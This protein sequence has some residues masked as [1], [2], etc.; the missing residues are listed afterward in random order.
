[1]EHKISGA[2]HPGRQHLAE[3]RPCQDRIRMARGRNVVCCALADGAGSRP[4]SQ[5]G[6]ECVTRTVTELL[7]QDFERLWAL[8]E[9]LVIERILACCT[10]ALRELEHPIYDLACTLEFCGAHMDGRYLAGHL[11]DGVMILEQCGETSVFSY[12]ENGE[13]QN[14]TCFITE[15]DAKEYLRIKR[16]R[17]NEGGVLLLMSD[18]MADS[19]FQY[20]TQTPAKVCGTLAEWIRDGDEEQVSQALAENMQTVFSK[21]TA[22][23]MSLILLCWQ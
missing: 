7:A 17:W 9:P 21:H 14:E 20:S 8:E 12:P 1:M 6:A 13:Y 19:L 16:G 10:Q 23:D 4:S 2:V 15:E 3:G 18:G 22:D 5:L 11:G